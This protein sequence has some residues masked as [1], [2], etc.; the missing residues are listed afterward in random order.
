MAI[1]VCTGFMKRHSEA[2]GT[3]VSILNYTHTN[4][5]VDPEGLINIQAFRC[6]PCCNY[7]ALK[8]EAQCPTEKSLPN[9][10]SLRRI[11]AKVRH[12]N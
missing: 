6:L 11:D 12:L 10:E 3:S 4:T 1:L 2:S 8:K 9:D 7:I 5:K